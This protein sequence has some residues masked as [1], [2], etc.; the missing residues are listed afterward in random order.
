VNRAALLV[1]LAV[2]LAVA[3]IP[4]DLFI[5]TL[6]TDDGLYYPVIARSIVTTGM[7]SYDG[8]LTRTNGYHPLW[9]WTMLP[10]ALLC[11]K[12]P[13][14]LYLWFIK[15]LMV[16]VVLAAIHAWGGLVG[17]TLRDP[18][19]TATFSVF[20]GAYWWSVY[21]LYS[22]M[23]TPLV[24]LCM[25]I[26][27]RRLLVARDHGPLTVRESAVLG[28]C[29]GLVML[30]RLDTVFFLGVSAIYLLCNRLRHRDL[31][32]F[33]V[34]GMAA[35]AMVAPYLLWNLLNFGHVVPVSGL[36]KTGVDLAWSLRHFEE[37]WRDKLAKAVSLFT[38]A[39][40]ALLAAGGACAVA[41][42][43][44]ELLRNL[45]AW[46]LLALLVPAAL[47][48]YVYTTFCMS[49]GDVYWYQYTEYLVG[50]LVIATLAASAAQ[51]LESRVGARAR[52]L[53]A[54]AAIICVLL[55][56]FG[57][58]RTKI[59]SEMKT[60][61]LEA[62]QW[63]REHLPRESRFGMFDSG[64][65]RFVSEAPTVPL[66]GLAGD[67]TLLDLAR[68]DDIPGI[69]SRYGIDYVITFI[70]QSTVAAIPPDLLVWSS[71][72]LAPPPPFH[73]WGEAAILVMTRAEAY[74]RMQ[75]PPRVR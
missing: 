11:G 56:L 12:L 1:V 40:F 14:L 43:R 24:L 74:T 58:G 70:P 63:A 59:P 15:A 17:R 6:I 69:V 46:N 61:R 29:M 10:V 28:G 31:R 18:V 21:T 7:S 53:P 13:P 27:L 34:T 65:F 23:E 8:G 51:R 68:E 66:N 39:G 62:A 5:R 75:N 47:L 38:P 35:L 57:H 50:F 60:A 16:A 2:A 45:R 71:P 3:A 4:G 19:A 33:V 25:A 52:G 32:G 26:F 9:C 41:I 73:T 36:K 44:R 30:S 72:P 22:L 42:A 37:F 49:E 20:L 67:A 64:I 48:H 55:V 54:W